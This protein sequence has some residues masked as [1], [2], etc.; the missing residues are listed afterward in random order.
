MWVLF[1]LITGVDGWRS[2]QALDVKDPTLEVTLVGPAGF[3][4]A[5]KGVP[6]GRRLGPLRWCLDT[7]SR[8]SQPCNDLDLWL[9]LELSKPRR[10]S[11]RSGI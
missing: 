6:A 4:G 9:R 11:Q 8:T 1:P 2:A 10:V 7:V 3:S 5:A